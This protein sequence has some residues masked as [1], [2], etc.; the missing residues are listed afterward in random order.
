MEDVPEESLLQFR[1]TI[2]LNACGSA[3]ESG[4]QTL[5]DHW[6]KS[7]IRRGAGAF[8]GSM[9]NIRSATAN[10]FGIEVYRALKEGAATTLGQAV[11][12]ARRRSARDPSDPTRLAYA[13]YGEDSAEINLG[14][15]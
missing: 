5:F 7:F 9:W 12:L 4:R 6:A 1:P 11:D 8:I 10:R 14:L 13:L 2:F 3:G 15:E